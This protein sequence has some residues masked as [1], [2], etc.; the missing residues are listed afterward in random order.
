MDPHVIGTRLASCHLRCHSAAALLAKSHR[1]PSPS[2][3]SY[4]ATRAA[5]ARQPPAHRVMTGMRELS[6]HTRA[7]VRPRACDMT[8]PPACLR[9]AAAFGLPC[10]RCGGRGGA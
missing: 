6:C 3:Q 2:G 8:S 7:R 9:Q 4:P 1:R 5:R 10:A